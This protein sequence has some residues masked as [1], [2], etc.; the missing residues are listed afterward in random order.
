MPKVVDR[1]EQRARIRDA[2]RLVFARR[3]IAGTGLA[4]I[5]A[6]AGI[7]RT[8]IY[9][10]YPDKQALVRDLARAL[11][12]EEARLFEQALS[13]SGA[14]DERIARLVTAVIEQFFAWPQYGRP[15][16]EIWAKESRQLRGLMRRLRTQLALLIEEGQKRGEVARELAPEETA[17]LVIALI[18][19]LM[20]QVFIDPTGVPRSKAMRRTLKQI[21][22]QL[23]SR[24]SKL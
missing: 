8:G 15:L 5:A 3:G 16:L 14:V 19:G 24:K 4:R 7:S 21:V 20:L 10:Y 2:A 6:E 13:S 1:A 18:D 17:T 12:A 9:H 23:I 11:L 22:R